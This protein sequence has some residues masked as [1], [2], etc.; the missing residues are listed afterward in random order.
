MHIYTR[1]TDDFEGRYINKYP[2]T[3]PHT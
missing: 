2:I 1:M 3:C